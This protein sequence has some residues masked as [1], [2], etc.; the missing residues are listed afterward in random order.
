MAPEYYKFDI[1]Q[2]PDALYHPGISV[3]KWLDG[4]TTTTAGAEGFPPDSLNVLHEIPW[5]VHAERIA[6]I[7][8]YMAWNVL[9]FA[10]PLL[11]LSAYLF[12]PIGVPVLYFVLGYVGVLD[13]AM[14]FFFTP[15]FIRKYE[16][17]KGTTRSSF[18]SLLGDDIKSNQFLYTE[19]NITKYLSV[20]FVW[21][22]SLQRPAMEN[23]PL[24]FCAVPHGVAP[25]A[26]TA[27]PLWSVLWNDR[28]CRWTAAPLVLKIP[29]VGYFMK[30]IGYIPAAQKPILETLTKKEQ[31]VGVVLDGI[32]GMFQPVADEEI[33]IVKKRKGI[34][35][36]ALKAGASLVPVFGFGHTSLW[37]VV[38][39]PFGLLK[40]LSHK[41]GASLTPFFGRF[42]WFLGRYILSSLSFVVWLL[43]M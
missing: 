31:N 10:L 36:I 5:D 14:R 27:Y 3:K 9:P 28:L 30:K 11:C 4:A 12:P 29:L 18:F 43:L 41:T 42:G 17:G 1:G 8:L 22:K 25:L 7:A 16:L 26:V 37:R 23:T 2:L 35:K 33:A 39:D 15:Y 34:V 6:G 13:I 24:I 21:P 19:R 40:W 38:Q 32:D 20:C